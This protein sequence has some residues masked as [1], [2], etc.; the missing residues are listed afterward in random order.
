MIRGP[1]ARVSNSNCLGLE[2]NYVERFFCLTRNV[3]LRNDV[4]VYHDNIVV[5]ELLANVP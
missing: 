1:L 4:V 2:R 3:Q 5:V